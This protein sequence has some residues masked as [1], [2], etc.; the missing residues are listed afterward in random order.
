L[1]ASDEY[2]ARLSDGIVN[3]VKAYRE[4]R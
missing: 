2:K 1:L 4:G 3:A